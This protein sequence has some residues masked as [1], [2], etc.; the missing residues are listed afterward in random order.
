MQ[1]FELQLHKGLP[2]ITDKLG[3]RFILDTGSPN[4]FCESGQVDLHEGFINVPKKIMHVDAAYLQENVGIQLDGL[5]GLDILS[6]KSFSIQYNSL[7]FTIYD[8]VNELHVVDGLQYFE[9]TAMIF[10]IP[11]SINDASV[12]LILDTGAHISYLNP[13]YVSIDTNNLRRTNDFNP[14]LGN[15]EASMVEEFE[16]SINGKII[17]HEVGLSPNQLKTMLGQLRA[18]GVFGYELFNKMDFY[19]LKEENRIA[20][21]FIK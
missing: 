18:G 10:K 4:S 8:S 17:I 21:K 5:L 13:E 3:Q 2:I 11:V 14:L 7:S 15:F 12:N 19:Y 9:A 20:I 1:N 6:K 16:Y